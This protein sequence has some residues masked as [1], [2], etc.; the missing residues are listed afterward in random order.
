MKKNSSKKLT[1]HNIFFTVLFGF[2]LFGVSSLVVYADSHLPVITITTPQDNSYLSTNTV[3]FTGTASDDVTVNNVLI[4]KAYFDQ[5]PVGL[6]IPINPDGSWVFSKTF[7]DG[8]HE[9]TLELMDG[10]NNFQEETINFTVDTTRPFINQIKI[11][12]P[13]ITDETLF[14]PVEDMTQVPLDAKIFVS[15]N[16]VSPLNYDKVLSVTA[17]GIPGVPIEM[18]EESRI[19]NITEGTWEIILNPKVPFS[20]NTSYFVYLNPYISDSVGQFIFPKFFK[21]STLS[22]ED[23]EAAH[24]NYYANT[25]SCANCHSTHVAT[26]KALEGG[27]YGSVSSSNYCMACHDGTTGAPIIGDFKSHKHK[28]MGEKTDTC[29]SCHNPHL[30]W[31][32]DNPNRLKDH[33]VYE[34]QDKTIGLIDSDVQLCESCHDQDAASVKN[35]THY[36]PLSYKKALTITGDVEDFTLCFQCHDGNKGADIKQFY[37]LPEIISSSGHNIIATDN[38]PLNGQMPCADCH[39]THGTANIKGL[40]TKLGHAQREDAYTTTNTEW[41]EFDERQFCLKCHNNSTEMYGKKATL[42]A[43]DSSGKDIPEHSP[44]DETACSS[45]HGTGET[46]DQKSQ[47]AAHAPKK[48]TT[49]SQ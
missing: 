33:Y 1:Y 13:G 19:E 16:D 40:K 11:I 25:Q 22:N 20:Y 36:R 27:K 14:L 39:V 12:P 28:Q 6:Q 35:E 42:F 9:V 23:P 15:I 32:K 44:A 7:A 30:A 49:T 26:G 4:L 8:K 18:I 3:N 48:L 29:T 47:S 38:S 21:F 34:H 2:L 46:F 41:T 45:C 31:S 5:D 10:E 17:V 43:K 24:G 37:S